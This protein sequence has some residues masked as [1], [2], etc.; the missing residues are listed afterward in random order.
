MKKTFGFWTEEKEKNC[1]FDQ[2]THVNV[3]IMLVDMLRVLDFGVSFEI[4]NG[5]QFNRFYFKW[6]RFME[7]SGALNINK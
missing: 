2:N 3:C 5:R 6:K 4:S 7:F 1:K